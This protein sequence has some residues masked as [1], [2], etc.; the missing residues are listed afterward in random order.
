MWCVCQDGR[1]E[2]ARERGV[3]SQAL[4]EATET[5]NL[6]DCMARELSSQKGRLDESLDV[7]RD[8]EQDL[9]AALEAARK[10]VAELQASAENSKLQARKAEQDKEREGRELA[11]ALKLMEERYETTWTTLDQ[12]V[13]GCLTYS[14]MVGATLPVTGALGRRRPVSS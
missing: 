3:Y 7:V 9:V 8:G 13:W 2:W 6:L 12:H 4:E 11:K 5:I 10:Q 1:L 14:A